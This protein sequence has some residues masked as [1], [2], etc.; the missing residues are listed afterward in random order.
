[1][2]DRQR[3]YN[4]ISTHTQFLCPCCVED[5]IMAVY[6]GHLGVITARDMLCANHSPTPN[7]G[8]EFERNTGRYGTRITDTGIVQI[9]HIRKM[10]TLTPPTSNGSES[11][12]TSLLTGML[13]L[14]RR[15][16]EPD[17]YHPNSPVCQARKARTVHSTAF[18]VPTDPCFVDTN[19]IV[20]IIGLLE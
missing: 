5:K 16:P 20:E 13:Y 1:M 19:H 4:Y 2:S 11:T 8:A 9:N 15:Y 18:H 12:T 3:E 7:V 17:E 6:S 10:T 14:C